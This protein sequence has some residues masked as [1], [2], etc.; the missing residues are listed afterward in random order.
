[1]DGTT[2]PARGRG[3]YLWLTCPHPADHSQQ[4]P[5]DAA[6]YATI[7]YETLHRLDDRSFDW[8]AV[9]QPPE[10]PEWAGVLDRLRRASG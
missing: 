3:A 2:L 7:L 10:W 8:I 1:M 6:A 5:P 9:E 4:M